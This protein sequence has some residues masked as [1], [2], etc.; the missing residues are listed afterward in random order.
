MPR[1]FARR[2]R[3]RRTSRIAY[4]TCSRRC[5][6]LAKSLSRVYLIFLSCNTIS[7]IL[8]TSSKITVNHD[9]RDSI[10]LLTSLGCAIPVSIV[11][12][13]FDVDQSCVRRWSPTFQRQLRALHPSTVDSATNLPIWNNLDSL[14]P[15]GTYLYSIY[16]LINRRIFQTS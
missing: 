4:G 15:R 12:D 8:E 14:N 11:Q 6:F 2:L 5:L 10:M 13:A 1:I 3:E 9:K 7:A 16:S